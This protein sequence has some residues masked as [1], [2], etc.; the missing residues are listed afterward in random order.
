MPSE[1][2][3]DPYG[4][5]GNPLDGPEPE[6]EQAEVGEAEGEGADS[7]ESSEPSGDRGGP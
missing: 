3:D 6:D 5:P 1:H 4:Q 2:P 7:E